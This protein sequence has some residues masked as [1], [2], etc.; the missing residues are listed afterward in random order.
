[1]TRNEQLRIVKQINEY[2]DKVFRDVDTDNTQ[3]SV[4]LEM[5]RPE[6]ERLA[7]EHG[8]GVADIFVMYMDLHSAAQAE[9]E[10]QLKEML[11]NIPDAPK[12]GMP[13]DF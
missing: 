1:M 4:Q 3:M 12:D 5:L 13:F 9:A 8:L 7:E 6:M 11:E 10:M 2:A